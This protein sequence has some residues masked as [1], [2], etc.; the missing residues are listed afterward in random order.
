MAARQDPESGRNLKTYLPG[1]AVR[2]ASQHSRRGQFMPKISTGRVKLVRSNG[3]CFSRGAGKVN[4]AFAEATV[5]SHIR[6]QKQ[7]QNEEHHALHFGL[8]LLQG[9]AVLSGIPE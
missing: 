2:G 6:H 9:L 7:H 4:L 3:S 5:L 8:F 1:V